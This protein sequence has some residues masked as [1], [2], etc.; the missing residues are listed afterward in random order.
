MLVFFGKPQ[1]QQ[2]DQIIMSGNAQ[3]VKADEEG[4]E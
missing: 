2:H 1:A 4:Y 3:T